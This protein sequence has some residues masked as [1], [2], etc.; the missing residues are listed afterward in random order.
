MPVTTREHTMLIIGKSGKK[1]CCAFSQLFFFF[2]CEY[3]EQ[4]WF[5]RTSTRIQSIKRCL[6]FL[7]DSPPSHSF[8]CCL[9]VHSY[10]LGNH[11]SIPGKIY[12]YVTEFRTF[13]TIKHSNSR[14]QYA[15]RI[16]CRRREAECSNSLSTDVR[17]RIS[18]KIRGPK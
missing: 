16:K 1:K 17:T 3:H 9:K 5:I 13:K 6:L 11:S 8:V 4:F 18:H 15:S 2:S 10:I 12:I 14:I 7:C